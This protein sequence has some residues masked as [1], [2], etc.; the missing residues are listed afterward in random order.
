MIPAN[1]LLNSFGSDKPKRFSAPKSRS[2]CIAVSGFSA[3]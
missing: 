1:A 3:S 2:G